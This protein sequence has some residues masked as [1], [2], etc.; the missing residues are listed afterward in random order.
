MPDTVAPRIDPWLNF[1][2]ATRIARGVRILGYVVCTTALML[3]ATACGGGDAP[4]T[5]DD[6][7]VIDDE[8]TDD[9]VTEQDPPADD[10]SPADEDPADDAPPAAETAAAASPEDMKKILQLV[11]DEE[12]LNK[13]LHLE[14]PGRFPLKISGEIPSGVELVK[15]TKPV[16]IV[17]GPKD[18]KDA[19]LVITGIEA[20]AKQATV[21]IR[22]DVEGVRGTVYLKKQNYGWEVS[23]SRFTER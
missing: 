7:E 4:K 13:F 5:P 15:S 23:S 21:K 9:I 6:T 10:A 8:S 11:I 22:W 19:V 1:P 12:E 14:E 20:T 17:D 16:E 3:G 2:M 18:K